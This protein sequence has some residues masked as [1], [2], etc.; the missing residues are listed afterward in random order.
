MKIRDFS[1]LRKK[2]T[3]RLVKKQ[4]FE[5]NQY[6]FEFDTG[7][8]TWLPGQ[9][10]IFSIPNKHVEGKKWRAF[11]VASTPEEGVIRI[12]TKIIDQPSSFKER[13][14]N[15]QEG[16]EVSVRGPF[17]W[18]YRQDNTT[19]MVMVAMGVG[20]TPILSIVNQHASDLA[21]A[22]LHV[23]YAAP[24]EHLLKD[25]LDEAAKKSMA[26]TVSYVSGAEEAEE[27]LD[28]DLA[29]YRDNAY[30]YISGAPAPVASV[31]N[32]IKGAGISGSKI[33]ADAYMGY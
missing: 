5:D 33:I 16:E 9:H 20:I 7:D 18:F 13:L 27:L 12:A 1:G 29:T 26:I 31:K 30:Y 19:P 23:I 14:R 6:V 21:E 32:H 4:A 11:S 15:L 10:G 22:P 8:A 28:K 24:V 17:G 3:I 2:T 25:M